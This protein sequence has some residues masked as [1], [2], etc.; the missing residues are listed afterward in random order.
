M[1]SCHVQPRPC[2]IFAVF[3]LTIPPA[4]ISFDNKLDEKQEIKL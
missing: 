2:V 4:R 1:A 3:V